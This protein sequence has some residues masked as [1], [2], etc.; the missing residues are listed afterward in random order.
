MVG[1]TWSLPIQGLALHSLNGSFRALLVRKDNHGLFLQT[2]V[3]LLV[4]SWLIL[5]MYIMGDM[6]QQVDS[7]LVSLGESHFSGTY[8]GYEQ[9]RESWLDTEVSRVLWVKCATSKECQII[10][11]VVSTVIDS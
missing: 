5:V 1:V 3:T 2:Q 10:Q 11:I 7:L 8:L 9:F 6:C 4:P